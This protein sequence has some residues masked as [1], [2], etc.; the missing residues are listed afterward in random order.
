MKINIKAQAVTNENKQEEREPIPEG[1]HNAVVIDY[2]TKTTKAGNG[3]YL[4]LTYEIVDDSESKGRW[5]WGSYN[6]VNP[7]PRAVAVAE[8]QL[9]ELAWCAGVE[10]L[11]DPHQLL[12][13][14]VK[15]LLAHD[16]WEGRVNSKIKGYQK[17][18]L[19]SN[20]VNPMA[21]ARPVV[22]KPDSNDVPF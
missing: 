10:N 1:W 15:I 21:S 12:Q 13:I 2:T 6:L 4:L 7:S 11:T 17:C 16:E 14:P 18:D 5:F 8:K 22:S 19:R 20:G 3:E 9:A